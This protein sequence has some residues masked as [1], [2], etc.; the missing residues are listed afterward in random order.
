MII[1]K[2][3]DGKTIQKLDKIEYTKE[4]KSQVKQEIFEIENRIMK[5]SYYYGS[6]SAAHEQVIKLTAHLLENNRN[7]VYNIGSVGVYESEDQAKE[8]FKAIEDHINH[9]YIPTVF[10]MPKD[11]TKVT[12][13][14]AIEALKAT[15]IKREK[16]E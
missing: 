5:N 13:E 9:D 7:Y 15:G 8:V 14:S 2:S 10:V 3:Q 4:L 1:I 12:A 16:K 6:T 11:E